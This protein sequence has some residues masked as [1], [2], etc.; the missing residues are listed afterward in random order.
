MN[1]EERSRN[2]HGVAR[3]FKYNS[4]PRLYV[5]PGHFA[6]IQACCCAVSDY[7]LPESLGNTFLHSL[8]TPIPGF[9]SLSRKPFTH[10]LL[11]GG[12]NVFGTEARGESFIV[13]LDCTTHNFHPQQL[14]YADFPFLLFGIVE[15]V[16]ESIE[17]SAQELLARK[18][19][20]R[21]SCNTLVAVRLFK[22]MLVVS[23]GST[24][25]EWEEDATFFPACCVLDALEVG[26]DPAFLPAPARNI[27]LDYPLGA[28]VVIKGVMATVTGYSGQ[29][30]TLKFV[31]PPPLD[32][33]CIKS[34][35]AQPYTPAHVLGK[36]IKV[37]GLV[38]SK[39]TSSM[40]VIDAIHNST[41]N[42]GLQL[43]F[44]AKQVCVVGY[45]RKSSRGWEFSDAAVDLVKSFASTF[46]EILAGLSRNPTKDKYAVTDFFAASAVSRI[47]EVVDWVSE[48]VSSLTQVPLSSTLLPSV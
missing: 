48:R 33:S 4:T 11:R 41:Y 1:E 32:L 8:A 39:L 27:E 21:L 9:P 10:S 40:T 17:E 24:R 25:H 15:S 29:G 43:K 38:L 14:V 16:C 6:D 42:I 37:T 19:G 44:E 28:G 35:L 13:T 36:S 46:P 30:L 45:S 47:S 22:R 26:I 3:L 5:S 12:V 23:D 34:Y 31:K 7:V 2:V 20:L 18:R